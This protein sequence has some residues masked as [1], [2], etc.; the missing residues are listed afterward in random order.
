MAIS[1]KDNPIKIIGYQPK[2][3]NQKPTP[4]KTGSK[5]KKESTVFNINITIDSEKIKSFIVDYLSENDIVSVTRCG[6]CKYG[7]EVSN[8]EAPKGM[9][10]YFCELDD[11]HYGE[12]EFCSMGKPKEEAK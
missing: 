7:H 3:N 1:D 8:I 5:C 12:N 9:N 4:P 6:K 11:R 2:G 10:V